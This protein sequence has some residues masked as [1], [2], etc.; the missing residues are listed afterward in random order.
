MD[1]VRMTYA[2]ALM[3]VLVVGLPGCDS[4]AGV[5]APELDFTFTPRDFRPDLE[6]SPESI[7]VTGARIIVRGIAL[8]NCSDAKPAGEL[9]SDGRTIVLLIDETRSEICGPSFSAFDYIARIR[10]V[11]AGEHRLRVR[12]IEPGRVDG[13]VTAADTTVTTG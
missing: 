13:L 10:E 11:D 12:Q 4:I 7:E 8:T 1:P 2:V 5:R 9:T 3:A 6:P